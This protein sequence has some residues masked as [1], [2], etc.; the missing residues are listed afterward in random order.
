M[1]KLTFKAA[2]IVGAVQLLTALPA[3]AQITAEVLSSPLSWKSPGHAFVCIG[4]QTGAGVKEECYG[5]YP[6]NKP[7]EVF[8]G[9]PG[10]SNEFQKNP[11][12]FSDVKWSLKKPIS[13]AQRRSFFALVDRVNAGSYKLFTNNCGDFVSSAVDIFGWHNVPK[14]PLPEPY[15]RELYAANISFVHSMGSFQRSG[16]DWAEHHNSTS[17]VYHFRHTGTDDSWVYARDDSRNMSL[18]LPFR[19]G[20]CQ[21]QTTGGWNNLYNVSPR[22]Q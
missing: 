20:Y 21:W 9:A 19:G 12:R 13:D 5:F 22:L 3:A 14:G 4:M 2:A 6:S 1:F 18:R 17:T 8:I 16:N 15:V 7:D 11:G 10:L